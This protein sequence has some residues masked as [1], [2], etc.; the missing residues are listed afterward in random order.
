MLFTTEFNKVM[1]FIKRKL[2]V[3]QKIAYRLAVQ[4]LQAGYDVRLISAGSV[5]TDWSYSNARSIAG[6]FWGLYKA[7]RETGDE[8]RSIAFHRAANTLYAMA[9]ALGTVSAADFNAQKYVGDS[10]ANE[11]IDFY[12]AAHTTGFTPRT[13]TLITE[14]NATEYAQRVH[15]ACWSH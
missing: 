3:S 5:F 2:G 10:I 11:V 8:G 13:V 4:A 15:R 9:D 1:H 7:Y 14:H 6:H 12:L